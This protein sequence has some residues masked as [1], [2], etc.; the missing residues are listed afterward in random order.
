MTLFAKNNGNLQKNSIV[1]ILFGTAVGITV[2]FLLLL[3]FSFIMTVSSIPDVAAVVFS[4][5]AIAVGSFV[6][7]FVSL[8]KIGR[9]GLVNGLICGALIAVLHL[10]LSLLFGDGGKLLYIIVSVVVELLFA[11][12]GGVVSVNARAD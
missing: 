11:V 5:A 2:C 9:Q 4:F 3:A 12:F 7:G 8:W 6:A 10:I 1:K